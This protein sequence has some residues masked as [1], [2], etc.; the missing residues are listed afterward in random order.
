MS[1]NYMEL[2][3]PVLGLVPYILIEITEVDS[4]TNHIEFEVALGG[5]LEQEHLGWLLKLLVSK[6]E[7]D[8]ESDSGTE[9]G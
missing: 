2:T 4:D 8:S 5:G 7:S 9:S 1:D 3:S 6:I